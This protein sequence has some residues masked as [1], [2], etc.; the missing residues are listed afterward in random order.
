MR[1]LLH[2]ARRFFGWWRA[3]RPGPATQSW[4]AERLEPAQ[5]RLFWE[6]AA[7]DQA[8][9]AAAAAYV[10]QRQ[11]DRADLIAAALLHDVGKA[12]SRLG[13]FRRSLA[14]ALRWAR[15]PMTR[16]MS[17]YLDHGPIGADMLERSGAAEM[18]ILFARWHT[19][20]EPPAGVSP[21]E[22]ALLREADRA[23]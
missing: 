12:V 9:A 17:A 8:H 13:P 21:T 18:A 1:T 19:R 4:I 23:A 6:Q 7:Q 20:A 14:T 10:A 16:R 11:P 15:V 5:A 22:W 2:L 3:G